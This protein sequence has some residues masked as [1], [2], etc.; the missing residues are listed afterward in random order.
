LCIEEC[1]ISSPIELKISYEKAKTEENNDKNEIV[2]NNEGSDE[3]IL[4]DIIIERRKHY[5]QK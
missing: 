3:N 5:C 1:N 4:K 2:I